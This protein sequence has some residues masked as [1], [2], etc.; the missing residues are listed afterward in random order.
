MGN[1]RGAG[2]RSGENAGM[3]AEAVYRA[4]ERGGRRPRRRYCRRDVDGDGG[5][6]GSGGGGGGGGGSYV[7]L[8]E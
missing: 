6:G 1:D 3:R 5:G 7:A 4:T 8:R 2:G